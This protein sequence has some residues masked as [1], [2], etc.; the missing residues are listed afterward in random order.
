MIVCVC[1]NVN[2]EKIIELISFYKIKTVDELRDKISI[3]NQCLMCERYIS[4]LIELISDENQ[5]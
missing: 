1:N 5:L 4:H 2:E 3:S